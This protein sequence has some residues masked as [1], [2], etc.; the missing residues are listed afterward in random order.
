MIYST[1]FFAGT[2]TTS[3]FVNAITVPSGHVYVIRD[4]DATPETAD[5]DAAIR[6]YEPGVPSVTLWTAKDILATTT[7]QW[8][9]RQVLP[10]GAILRVT[11]TAVTW[12]LI[13]SGYDLTALA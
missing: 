2:V 5:S 4:M 10:A 11:V 8:R 9:G 13:I 7:L 1:R 12:D 6:V 3:G